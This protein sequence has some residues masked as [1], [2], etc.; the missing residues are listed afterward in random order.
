MVL[1]IIDPFCARN[2]MFQTNWFKTIAC[3]WCH[4]SLYQQ[5]WQ[6]YVTFVPSHRAPPHLEH[7]V[8]CLLFR[9]PQE[10][11]KEVSGRKH[12]HVPL[13]VRGKQSQSYHT[14]RNHEQTPHEHA[15]LKKRSKIRHFTLMAITGTTSQVPYLEVN[16]LQ[17]IWRSGT[18]RW[19]LC[20]RHGTSMC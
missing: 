7:T 13:E 19:I 5:S 18:Q 8:D 10:H 12:Q 3:C 14:W 2:G 1:A 4:G 15:H 17:L 6:R 20:V 9:H 16:S 11:D